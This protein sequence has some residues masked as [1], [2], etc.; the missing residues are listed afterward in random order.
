MTFDI[1]SCRA[2]DSDIIILSS[3]VGLGP[4]HGLCW[5]YRLPTSGFS[6]LSSSVFLHCAQTVL[7]LFLSHLSTTHLLILMAPSGWPLMA[8]RC[9]LPHQYNVVVVW[10]YNSF[11]KVGSIVAQ[12]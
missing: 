10:A 3:I 11:L 5:Q 1:C 8:S 9:L 6:S 12:A 7:F 2:M 4:H